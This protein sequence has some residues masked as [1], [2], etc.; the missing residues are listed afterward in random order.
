MKATF[1]WHEVPAFSGNAVKRVSGRPKGYV[2]DSGTVCRALA[3]STPKAV[4]DHP[5][6]GALFETAVYGEVRKAASL[7]SPPPVVHHWRTRGGAK[8]DL[9]LERDGVLFPIE[10]KA[11]SQP[12]RRDTSGLNAFRKTYPRVKVAPGLVIA[13]CAGLLRLSEDDWALPWDAIAP[14]PK[15]AS[16]REPRRKVS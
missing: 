12:S 5:A 1:Q 7:M 14:V 11:S 3:I 13:P 4:A 10:V 2:A 6:W 9:V 8:V 15:P 16:D